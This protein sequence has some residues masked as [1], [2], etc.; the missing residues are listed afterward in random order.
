M[1][2]GID[3]RKLGDGGVGEYVRE[4]V[5]AAARIEPALEIVAFGVPGARELL[6][7]DGV[8]W[9]DVRAG[10]YSLAEHL[11]LPGTVARERVDLFHEPHYVLPLGLSGRAVVTVHDLIHVL[12][13]R[14]VV[15]PIYARAMIRSAC[16]RATRVITVSETSARDLA[17]HLGVERGK[18]RVIANG[19]APRF[20]RL[21]RDQVEGPLRALGIDGPYVLFVGNWLPHKNVETLVRAWGRLAE[22]RPLLVLCGR[23]FERATGVWQAAEGT[24]DRRK[25]R[26]VGAV[27]DAVLVALY[28]GAEMLA[29]TSLY[30][31]FCL[32]VVEAFAC[33][34]PVLASDAGPIPE[35]AGD[36]A[37]LV[38]PQRVDTIAGEMYRLL[39]DRRLRDELVERGLRRAREFS[40]EESARRHLAVYAEALDS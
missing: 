34:T 15:H 32:P 17:A 37:R 16:R 23:G 21:P 19:V 4:L 22:P 6:P 9:V 35:V 28:N 25:V 39:G 8:R 3:V 36:A 2:L 40:W 31:G 1:R 12:F 38:S 30:E 27:D 11:R 18:I 24:G 10:K 29:T 33:G 26:A 5:V 7:V 13:P 20:R 14:T